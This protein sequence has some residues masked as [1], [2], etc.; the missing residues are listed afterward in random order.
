MPD[1]TLIA[2]RFHA[3]DRLLCQL[4]PYWQFQPFHYRVPPWSG[5][6]PGLWPSLTALSEAEFG[7]LQ[8]DGPSR[9]RFLTAWLPEVAELQRLRQLPAMRGTPLA[10][11]PCLHHAVPGRKWQQLTAF[12]PLVPSAGPVL[13]WCA[14]KGHLGRLLAGSSGRTVTS[15]ERDATLCR[16]GAALARRAGVAMN[17]ATVDVMEPAAAAYLG[18]A[19]QAVAL[20]ACGDLHRRLLRQLTRQRG[21]GLTLAPCCY[22][23]TRELPYRPLSGEGSASRLQLHKADLHMV[24]QQTATAP[25][26][27]AQQG[28]QEIVWRLAF[29]ELQRDCRRCDA[30]LPV[31]AMPRQLLR[32]DF[33]AFARWAAGRKQ[34]QLPPQWQPAHYLRLGEQRY[35]VLRRVE[36]VQHTFQRPLEIW[37][38]LDYALLLQEHGYRVEVGEFC[39]ARLT[40]RNLL[41]RALAP[42]AAL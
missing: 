1:A 14:G 12:A 36:W 2:P 34:L 23:L 8:Y 9:D 37:L 40:P 30:Y 27:I 21:A 35:R 7:T 15:L 39:D 28:R 5:L 29:D 17:F 18:P 38:V 13:E 24:V 19:V 42:E 11:A 31:P 22:H 16:E 10:P 3:L 33:A 25:H 4:R 32:G 41:L 20:H 6:T 26:R